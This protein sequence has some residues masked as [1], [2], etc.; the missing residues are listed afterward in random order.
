M[1]VRIYKRKTG[2]ADVN[3]EYMRLAVQRVVIHG[4][5]V[6]QVSKEFNIPRTTL[7]RYIK[8]SHDCAEAISYKPNY[9]SRLV[10][11]E[12]EEQELLKYILTSA[13]MYCG[14][15][16]KEARV[17]AFQFAAKKKKNF[18]KNWT[19][20]QIA[21][22]DWLD[23]FKKRHPE[24]SIR[25]P[26]PTSIARATAFNRENIATFF[27]NLE[28]LQERYHFEPKDIYNADETGV[29]TVPNAVKILSPKGMKQVGQLTSAERG[30]LVTVCCA[31]NAVGNSVPPML[32]F[33][34]VHFREY[35]L[36]GAPVGSIGGANQSGWMNYELFIEFMKHF[37]K[38][39]GCNRENP[40]LLILDNHES[41]I[42]I[43]II[44]TCKDNGVVILTLP[45]HCS[46]K[47]QPLDR[48]P[49]SSFKRNLHDG[50]RRWMLNHGGKPI[51]IYDLAELAGEAFPK[52]FTPHNIQ[53][54]FRI[55][56]CY[57]I[58]R[59]IFTDDDFLPSEVT[60]R[61]DPGG[62]NGG[63]ALTSD[64]PVPGPSHE[65][66]A[67][68]SSAATI[69]DEDPANV[70]VESIRPYPKAPQRKPNTTNRKRAKSSILTDTP[71]KRAMMN[72][73][74]KK[75]EKRAKLKKTTKTPSKKH[76]SFSAPLVDEN[77]TTSDEY[78][79]DREET[80][81]EDDTPIVEDDYVLV[82]LKSLNGKHTQYH[83]GKVLKVDN[84][85]ND[86][87]EVK[88]MRKSGKSGR[89]YVFP[90]VDDVSIVNQVDIIEKVPRPTPS[91]G[92]AR[93][94]ACFVFPFS[95]DT[96]M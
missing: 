44:D 38:Y 77:G 76:I 33:P 91:G 65:V 95:L 2:R 90:E 5:K 26:E 88:F 25:K 45:P 27:D 42:G 57:P 32:I 62:D 50:S 17:L 55:S 37:I 86:E 72:D 51:T 82:R 75:V 49:F 53:N 39:S 83:V 31:I 87:I 40:V 79:E 56:G 81:M 61:P 14:L 23:G 89:T 1:M 19:T 58:N 52:A 85:D 16:T 68:T 18:P 67:S 11:T 34:R 12:E 74:L 73:L 6:L 93:A 94:S 64:D 29:M 30:T 66:D 10:F 96:F 4:D 92:T 8:K 13:K 3:E 28:S 46:H 60:N 43:E 36:K 21:G 54:G 80:D 84:D 7:L 9:S 24:V 20:N 59:D 15:S 47:L 35:M 78:S 71:V 41:H 69:D 70:T 63:D 48:T 22:D